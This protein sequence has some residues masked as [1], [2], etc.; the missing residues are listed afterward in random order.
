MPP[1]TSGG[2]S[3]S[4]RS[5]A[6]TADA[7]WR[8]GNCEN[9]PVVSYPLWPETF[10]L[11]KQERSDDPDHVLLTREGKLLRTED[12]DGG[13]YKKTDAVR[14]A[15]RRLS[16]KTEIEFTLKACKKTSA[17]LLRGNRDY[18]GL[19]SL[20]FD[21]DPQ[22]VAEIHYTTIPQELLNEAIV[23]LG[24]ELGIIKEESR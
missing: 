24:R 7:G 4:E 23:W 19:Q 13:K 20:F 12:I 6:S 1:A 18:Q 10:E 21:H 3:I 11:L 22:T 15:I 17:S 8:A 16:K 14:L 9:V 2:S 5:T